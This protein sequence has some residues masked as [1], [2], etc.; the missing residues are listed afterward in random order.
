MTLHAFHALSPEAQFA[1]LGEL[2]KAALAHWP[3]AFDAPVPVKFRENAVFSVRDAQGRRYALRI[4]RPGYHDRAALEAELAWMS[5]LAH[6]GIGAP[7]VIANRSG[8]FLTEVSH[9][10]VPEARQVDLLEWLPGVPLGTAEDGVE[11]S[12]EAIVE[13][14]A[15]IGATAAILH[16][17]SQGWAGAGDL[18]RHHWDA[19][20]LIGADPLWGRFWEMPGLSAEQTCLL[21]AARARAAADLRDFGQNADRYGLI[22][23]D[24]VPENLLFDGP[25]LNLIDFDDSGFGWHLFELATAL[26]F[27]AGQPNYPALREAIF[28]GYRRERAL[29]AAHEALLPLFL[30]L[31]G[32]TYLGWMQTRSETETARAMAAMMIGKVCDLAQAYLVQS[33]G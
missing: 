28:A 1:A 12:G 7:P 32:T 2:A 10:A 20:G 18:A 29:P 22:H 31:R 26:F 14:F 25:R 8:G 3:G 24:F 6:S 33:E 4:H 16:N 15:T 21:Q 9:P 19:Q 30:F 27:I 11:P 23:A 17:H 5:A 13:R